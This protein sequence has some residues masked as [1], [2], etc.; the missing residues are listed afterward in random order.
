[1]KTILLSLCLALGITAFSQSPEDALR[2]AWFTQN[3]TARNVA[4]GGVMGSLG[5]EITANHVNPAGIG[6]YKTREFVLSPGFQLNSNKFGYRGTDTSNQKNAF[7]YGTSG[8]VF[9][10]RNHTGNRWTS[11]AFAISVMQLASYNNRVQ[12]SGVNN[13]SSFSEQYLEE[14]TRDRADTNAALSN[15]IFGSS[16]AFRTYLIDTIRGAGGSVMGYQSLVP[17]STGVRQRYDAI[18]R[19]GSH[20]IAI[21]G[22][23]NMDDRLYI[24]GSL[25]IPIVS[26]W[27]DI[28][29]RETDYTSNPNN[30]FSFFE[31]K[32]SFS[33]KGIGIGAK[34][35]LIYKPQ[36]FWRVGFAIHTPQLMS[37]TDRIKAEITANTESY[38]GLRKA[39]SD[40]LNSG[41]AGKRQYNLITPWRAIVSASYVFREIS[42]TRR[43]RAFISADLEYVNYRGARFSATSNNEGDNAL[44]NYY[45]MINE[46]IKDTYKGNINFRIGGELKWHTVMFRL[47]GAYYGSPYA[48]KS[49]NAN[50][51]LATGGLGYRNHG[52]FIDLGYA[53]NFTKDVVF[54][55]RLNDKPNTYAEQKGFKGNLVLTVGFK[56]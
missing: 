2:T 18:T 24:G 27:R 15:Y 41:N 53:H 42:D 52:I 19:G 31:Y 1:M 16:L 47:G 10:G 5:G 22:A 45:D 51:I 48:D 6:L 7:S 37:F 49:L 44:R 35:G 32:E 29:Y 56:F 20:E 38:A 3:G 50:R 8:F 30:Q 26:Y 17:I 13:F 55:Y 40:A 33:S 28:S 36:E 39:T 9:G 54:A 34:L 23:G 11:S 21:G 46:T 25:T 4:T 14:L 12:F 43:Q